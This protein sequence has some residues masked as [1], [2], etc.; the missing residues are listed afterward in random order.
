MK[1]EVR[2]YRGVV[3]KVFIDGKD[4]AFDVKDY[5]EDEEKILTFY[6]SKDYYDKAG[7]INR[8]RKVKVVVG[9]DTAWKIYGGTDDGRGVMWSE[10]DQHQFYDGTE[11]ELLKN[12]KER[13]WEVE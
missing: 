13:G 4:V 1:V 12:M 6:N 3:D 7:E 10:K 9:T 5:D 8:Q 2:T 11:A